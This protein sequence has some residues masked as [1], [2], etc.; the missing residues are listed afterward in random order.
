MADQEQTPTPDQTNSQTPTPTPDA[1]VAGSQG[2]ADAS[3]GTGAPAA[4]DADQSLLGTAGNADA[5]TGGGVE[6]GSAAGDDDQDAAAS[7]GPP[8]AYQLA[9][10]TIK[11]GDEEV[12]VEID[13]DLLGAAAPVFKDVGLTNDQAQKLAPLALE[14]EKRVLAR[15]NDDFSAWKNDLAQQVKADPELGGKNLDETMALAGRALDHFGASKD[16]DFRKL[17]DSTGLGNHPVMVRMF[18]DIGK[19]VGEDSKLEREDVVP[20]KKTDRLAEMYPND[21]PEKQK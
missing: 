16:S 9:P 11:E 2:G 15:Q 4:G 21:V 14:V 10:I 8:E 19:A 20:P 3:S 17:L 13:A 6:G 12:T 1:S 7:S 5:G 18:R